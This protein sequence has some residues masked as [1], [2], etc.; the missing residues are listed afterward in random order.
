MKKLI[1]LV[2]VALLGCQSEESAENGQPLPQQVAP[3]VTPVLGPNQPA[4]PSTPPPRAASGRR[5]ESVSQQLTK[6]QPPSERPVEHSE[7]PQD[8]ATAAPATL[9]RLRMM[10]DVGRSMAGPKWNPTIDRTS[11]RLQYQ[12]QLQIPGT[13]QT[14][15]SLHRVSLRSQIAVDQ[16]R[17]SKIVLNVHWEP[18][19][20]VLDTQQSQWHASV[21]YSESTHSAHR[22]VFSL[23]FRD[24]NNILGYSP[25][26]QTEP[27]ELLTSAEAMRDGALARFEEE[28]NRI[29]AELAE[30]TQV[31]HDGG[32]TCGGD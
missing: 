14:Q 12:C 22:P 20:A 2:T 16:G 29:E 15:P 21:Y 7:I 28:A 6:E 30:L 10:D 32:D 27:S 24:G 19:N 8:L 4:R 5:K 11:D 18:L 25:P 31:E 23:T 1:C 26:P 13:N 3:G 9:A 17:A